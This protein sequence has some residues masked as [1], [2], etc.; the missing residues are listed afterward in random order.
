VYLLCEESG[1]EIKFYLEDI[2]NLEQLAA[3]LYSILEDLPAPQVPELL[4][5]VRDKDIA[6]VE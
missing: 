5:F 1:K 6:I 3:T 4:V 2:Y